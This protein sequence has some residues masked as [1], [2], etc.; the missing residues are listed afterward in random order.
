[1]VPNEIKILVRTQNSTKA[2]M[3]EVDK[4]VD[5][6]AQKSSATFAETFSKNLANNLRTHLQGQADQIGQGIGDAIGESVGRRASERI[7]TRITE[8][9][10][11]ARSRF[12]SGGNGDTTSGARSGGLADRDTDTVNVN[13]DTDRQSLRSRFFEFGRD[14]AKRF[15]D[16]FRS[17]VGNVISGIFSGDVISTTL[18][19][20]LVA[21]AGSVLAPAIGAAI[22]SGVLLALSGGFIAAGLVG[23]F[24]DP[25]I[26]VAVKGLKAKAVDAWNNFSAPF[27]GPLEDLLVGDGGGSAS[28]LGLLDQ[29]TPG[30]EHLGTVLAPVAKTLG[31][32]IIG[33]L[34]NML[35]SIIRAVE[36]GAPLIETLAAE[37]PEIGR[38][39]GR[40]F[41]KISDAGP[42]AQ[43][44][45]EDLLEGVQFLIEIIGNLI[46]GFTRMYTVAR[47]AVLQ[48]VDIFVTGMNTILAHAVIA[49]GWIPG[50]GPKLRAAQNKAGEFSAKVRSE[51]RKIPDDKTFTLRFRI[52]GM[53]AASAAVSLAKMLAHGGIAGSAADGGL[54]SGMTW[55]GENGPELVKLP[56]GAQVHSNPDSMRMMQGGSSNLSARVTV[57]RSGASERDIIGALMRMLRIEI[58]Q[59]AGGNVQQ[60]LGR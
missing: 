23:A 45:F 10:R 35:P 25:R 47:F 31:T 29:I 50:L 58:D 59:V 18:K 28:I 20:G 3:Q 38:S 26:Q 53:A 17:S 37:L 19:V 12:T 22:T 5:E 33:M 6:L 49:F 55:V 46:A 60:A 8:R 16:G 9:L 4:A 42:S 21:L 13:V 44:F 36:A 32:G 40:F 41:D 27:K 48:M 34:Q 54:K 2:G 7:I 11:N 14:A 1:M 15:G 24:Q 56:P 51:L 57:D 39:L 30:L 43:I 52:V